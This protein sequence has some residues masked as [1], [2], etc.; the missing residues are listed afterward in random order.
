M[1]LTRLIS[2]RDQRTPSVEE[3]DEVDAARAE[4]SGIPAGIST[5]IEATAV[6]HVTTLRL[7]RQFEERFAARKRRRTT[8]GS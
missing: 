2:R 8:P 5:E 6:H 4:L 1:R 3:D 7:K